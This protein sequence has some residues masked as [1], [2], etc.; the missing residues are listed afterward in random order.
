MGDGMGGGGGS[1]LLFAVVA[2]TCWC[3]E[4]LFFCKRGDVSPHCMV[5]E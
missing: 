5:L 3:V 1:V 4:H 2:V